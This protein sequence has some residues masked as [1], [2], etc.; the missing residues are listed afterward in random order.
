MGKRRG[1]EAVGKS[2]K[3][4]PDRGSRLPFIYPFCQR[5]GVS[6]FGGR[7]RFTGKWGGQQPF[8]ERLADR[9]VQFLKLAGQIQECLDDTEELEEA[10]GKSA[11]FQSRSQ[12]VSSRK[13]WMF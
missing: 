12:S 1:E 7:R 9:I 6:D 2:R 5:S 4:A 11:G 8:Q 10:A 13:R 3:T